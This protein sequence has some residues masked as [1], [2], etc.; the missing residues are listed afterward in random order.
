MHP[1]QN[2]KT[3]IYV[4]VPFWVGHSLAGDF[5]RKAILVASLL[6]YAASPRCATA[7][8]LLSF[9]RRDGVIIYAFQLNIKI[10]C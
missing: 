6:G 3:N 10:K 1:C 8:P 5:R 2:K 7:F 9:T 4:G